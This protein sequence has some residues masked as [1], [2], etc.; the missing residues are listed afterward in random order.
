MESDEIWAWLL[1]AAA[2]YLLGSVS[3]AIIASFTR[4]GEDIRQYGSGNAGLTNALRTYGVRN[5]VMVAGIDLGKTVLAVLLGVWLLGRPW[6]LI[7]GGGGAIFGHVAPVYYRFRGGKGILCGAA[8]VLMLDWRLFLLA[9]AVFAASVAVSKTVSVGSV[10][11]CAV[12]P[13]LCVLLRES[14]A[15]TVFVTLTSALLIWMHRENLRR[16]DAGT[17]KKTV[18][19]KRNPRRKQ[20]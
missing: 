10:L 14:H 16:I 4:H 20:S 12:S 1:T 11:T 9:A 5:A 19:A 8:I 3:G 6:G 2:G 7:V 15:E 18:V 17:E 13:L